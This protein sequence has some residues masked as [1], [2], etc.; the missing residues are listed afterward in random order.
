MKRKT[1][2]DIDCTSPEYLGALS[3]SGAWR[4]ILRNPFA[5]GSAL[6]HRFQVAR[7]LALGNKRENFAGVALKDRQIDPK[8][9]HYQTDFDTDEAA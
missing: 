4:A 1:Q 9:F 2:L 7:D 6:W 8:R 3:V 5:Y